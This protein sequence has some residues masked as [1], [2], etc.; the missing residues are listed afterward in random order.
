MACHVVSCHVEQDELHHGLTGTGTFTVNDPPLS[1]T[2][3]PS[4]VAVT[5]RGSVD[6]KLSSVSRSVQRAT[7]LQALGQIQVTPHVMKSRALARG[8]IA[9][10]TRWQPCEDTSFLCAEHCIPFPHPHFGYYT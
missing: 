2:E 7:L 9:N 10:P 4:P 5:I 1:G 6:V 8:C 3:H